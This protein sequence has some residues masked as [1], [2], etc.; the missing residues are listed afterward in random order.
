MA[1][2]PSKAR[3]MGLADRIVCEAH[4]EAWRV[5]GT[6]DVTLAYDVENHVTSITG[7]GISAS[8]IYDGDGKRVK[9]TVGGVTTVYI[10]NYYERDN[11]TTVRKY[12]YAGAVRVAMRTGGQ[13]YYL[14]ND[15][16]T[17]TAITTNSSGVRQTELRYYAYGGTRYDAGGQMTFYRYTGQRIET[18]TGLYDYGARWY[19]PQIGRFLAADSIVPNPGDSQA[20]NRYM[21]VAGNPLKYT[22]PSGHFFVPIA[23]MAVT[24]LIGGTAGFVGSIAGQMLGSDG[25]LEE[26]WDAI[27]WK[28]V[29]VAT[30]VSATAGFFAPLTATT[31]VGAVVTNAVASGAQYLASQAVNGRQVNPADLGVSVTLGAVAGRVIGP[32]KSANPLP[33]DRASPWLSRW[34][35]EARQIVSEDLTNAALAFPAVVRSFAGGLTSNA[36][37]SAVIERIQQP[38]RSQSRAATPAPSKP[39][40]ERQGR[41]ARWQ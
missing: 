30:T 4:D 23:A 26:R 28:D 36:P 1:E 2:P 14:L 21:Y 6:L 5:N 10:G 29:G 16:L 34:A 13:T 22:D 12:Y 41:G 27:N 39:T 19:D 35:D 37:A 17:S 9:A 8:Y 31:V 7:S 33:P 40:R 15:H 20:L 18:G 25:T 11:G 3:I 24:G 38:S 32:L